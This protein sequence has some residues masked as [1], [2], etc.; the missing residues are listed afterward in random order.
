KV[1][2]F[3]KAQ[4]EDGCALALG[5]V[6]RKSEQKTKPSTEPGERKY[7]LN[8]AENAD[9]WMQP[10]FCQNSCYNSTPEPLRPHKQKQK[11]SRFCSTAMGF[12]MGDRMTQRG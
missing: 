1:L 2:R 3:E 11:R 12:E 4:A 10:F 5:F 7:T 9:F 6:D 8:L